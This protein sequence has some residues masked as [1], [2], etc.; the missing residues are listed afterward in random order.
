MEEEF[1]L[2]QTE[3]GKEQS[4]AEAEGL[5]EE[6]PEEQPE[7]SGKA[8]VRDR[9]RGFLKEL[10]FFAASFLVIYGIF[11]VF[12]PYLVSGESMNQTLS[13]RSFGFGCRYASIQRGDIV[14]YQNARTNG[15]DYIKRVIGC[16][17][18]TVR[19]EMDRVYVN[20]T[21]VEEPYAY[22]DPEARNPYASGIMN[23]DGSLSF[24]YE[25]E[26]VLGE[27]EYFTMGDNRYHSNDSR[28]IGAV[29]KQDIKCKMLW[30]VWGKQG[31]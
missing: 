31:R 12:P 21:L 15:K 27:D 8:T 1:D 26:W 19:I 23:A 22:H 6:E 25:R 28:A 20:G 17:G 29:H 9:L 11:Y 2:E 30:F 13:D 5:P 16:P 7:P 3:N 24:V 10:V 4:V 18:D 14:V